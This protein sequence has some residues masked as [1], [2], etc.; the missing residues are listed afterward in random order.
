MQT[1]LYDQNGLAL[2]HDPS[3][4]IQ[5]Q[6]LPPVFEENSCLYL[7]T[8]ADLLRRHHRIGQHAMMF[9]IATDEA[10]DIDDELDF[11]ICEFLLKRAT[12]E[13]G[14]TV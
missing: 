7:F 13:R 1:R 11:E 4:L 12:R 5:T 10:W 9:E 8:R 2:N 3:A 14:R 6:D